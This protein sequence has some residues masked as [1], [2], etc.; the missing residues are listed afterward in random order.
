MTTLQSTNNLLSSLIVGRGNPT[1]SSDIATNKSYDKVNRNNSHD[2]IDNT[3]SISSGL[4]Y[5]LL[6]YVNQ[7]IY[8]I[9]VKLFCLI[10]WRRKY[11]TQLAGEYLRLGCLLV[12]NRSTNLVNKQTEEYSHV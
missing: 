2:D 3:V 1:S 10:E 4:Y 11:N 9:M 8:P 7:C 5:A 6:R 12:T